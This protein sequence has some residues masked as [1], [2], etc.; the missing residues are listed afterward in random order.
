MRE[1][2]VLAIRYDQV[3]SVPVLQLREKDGKRIIPIWIG[4]I[5]A[6]AILS[7]LDDIEPARPMTHDLFTDVLMDHELEMMSLTLVGVED[8][9]FFAEMV[10]GEKVFSCRPSDGVALALRFGAPIWASEELIDEVGVETSAQ[11]MDE[12]QQFR[13]FLAE[14]SPDDFTS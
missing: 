4:A 5:E 11:E 9:V 2:E 14:V 12:M 7:E 10:I 8:G 3:T 6:S 1:L 13:N